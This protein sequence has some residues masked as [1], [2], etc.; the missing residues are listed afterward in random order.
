MLKN[1]MEYALQRIKNYRDEDSG[2]WIFG[3]YSPR[4]FDPSEGSIEIKTPRKYKGKKRLER[5]LKTA[6]VEFYLKQGFNLRETHEM[7]NPNQLHFER[8]IN[9]LEKY[10]VS[11]ER[12]GIFFYIHTSRE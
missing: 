7:H 12:Q 8:E 1:L 2:E 4:L 5:K 6:V 9:S 3:Q 10:L 11:I